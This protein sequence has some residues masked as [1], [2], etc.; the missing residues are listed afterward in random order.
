MAALSTSPSPLATSWGGRSAPVPFA[1]PR[2]VPSSGRGASSSSRVSGAGAAS[3]VENGFQEAAA[4]FGDRYSASQRRSSVVTSSPGSE[5]PPVA[6]ALPAKAPSAIVTGFA[7]AGAFSAQA[8]FPAFT[9]PATSAPRSTRTGLLARALS[10]E[11]VR[12]GCREQA[13]A[14]SGL[15]Q[16]ESCGRS[17]DRGCP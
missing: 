4:F 1:G 2:R 6:A 11:K 16:V 10:A 15:H 5:R 7:V 9:F 8:E 13:E 14:C 3:S 12:A 17:A